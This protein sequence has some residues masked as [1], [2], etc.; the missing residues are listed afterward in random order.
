MVE[1]LQTEI[2]PGG[3][4]PQFLPGQEPYHSWHQNEM[5]WFFKDDW[6]ITPSLT[7]NLG[8]R[9]EIYPAPTEQ[10][11]KGLAPVGNGAGVFG[12]SGS[13]MAS[14]FNPFA[15]GGT[16]TVIQAIGPGTP[17]PGLNYY[18]TDFKNFSPAVG[19]AW[20]VP[21]QD[22]MWKWISG[23]PNKM[24][25]RMGY[26]IGYQRLPIG[27]INVASGSE[28][29]YTVQEAEL[30]STNLANVVV[31][32]PPAGVP[33]SVVPTS[34]AGSHTQTMYAYEHNLRTPYTENY[35]VTITRALTRSVDHGPGLRGKQQP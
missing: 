34:G 11:G 27:L 14:L 8:V 18:D 1:T 13:T 7:L 4:N 19:L 32:V 28:P 35:N 23:G 20:A 29:G 25:V 21:G 6:K 26:S 12:I 17:N 16:P 2:S 24:T 10:Q 5:D 22:G 31:P 3:K 33:L 30:T 9:Q 15:T